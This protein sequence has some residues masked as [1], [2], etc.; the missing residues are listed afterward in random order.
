MVNALYHMI[1]H[2]HEGPAALRR[3]L[4]A[5]EAPVAALL[6]LAQERGARRIVITAVG[7]SWTAAMMAAPVFHCHAAL[8]VHFVPSTE[9]G[10]YA[11][12][13]ID[14]DA[15]VLVVSR[16]GERGPVV[17]ALRDAVRRGALGV[18]MT[19]YPE[20]LLARQGQATLLTHEGPEVTF[21]KTKSV[22]ASAGLLMRLGLALAD[23]GDREAIERLAGLREAP[24]AAARAIV[25]TEGPLRALLP[26][27]QQH[28]LVAI[29]GTGG[30]Y[31][32]ALEAGIKLQEA[33]YVPTMA[34]DTGNLLFGAL[35]A[36]GRQWLI[37]ALVTAADLELSRTMLRTAGGLGARRLAIGAPGLDLEGCHDYVL[38]LPDA[39]DPLLAPLTFLPPVQL[40]TYYWAVARGLNPDEPSSMRAMLDAMLPPGRE[41]PE[42]RE[43]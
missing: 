20:S 13:L 18:A 11:P 29:V 6:Q 22:I 3:T 41:E 42:L 39:P 17:E 19:A 10:Y 21:P 33:A 8:P 1:E 16:S 37:V 43:S 12:R 36:A 27:I 35:G 2:I 7:S 4:D 9:L 24:A 28:G 5:G 40:L 25:A 34:N 26:S 32:V 30:N 15:M 38:T 14:R 23:P 31:G